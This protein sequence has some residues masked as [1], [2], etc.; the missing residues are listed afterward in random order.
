MKLLT[1]YLLLI[2][3]LSASTLNLSMSSSPSRLNPI[4]ANDS[5][6][7][8]ISDWL[9]NGLFKYDKN[10]NHTVD[11]AQSYEYETPTKL[12]IKLRNNVLWHDGVKFTSKDVVFTYEKIIDPKVFNSIKS[13]FQEVQSVKA[14]DDFTL[15]IIYKQP[16]FKAIETWM[17]GI[18]PYHLLKDE[19]NLMT[20]SFNK[21]PIGTGSYKLKEFK[22][23]QD[24]ELIANE[25][26]FEGIPKIDKILY[27]FLPDPNTSFL[28]LKQKK[29]DIGG[30]TPIQIDRQIDDDFKNKFTIIQKPSF[31]Y[32]YLGFNLNNEKFKDLRIRQALSLAIDRQELVDILFFG[33]GKICNGPFLPDSFAYNEKI[34]PITQNIEKAKELLKELGYDENNPFTFEVVTNTGNDTRINTA[35]ILQYQLEKVGVKMTIRVMEWQA[36]LNTV[37]HPKK[38]DAVILGWSLGLMP[39][40]YPLWHSSSD[41]LGGFN[42]VSY[43]N[44][45]VDK[46][47]EDGINTINREELGKIYK[48]IFKIIS[49]DLPYLFLYIPDGI[50]VVN[51]EIKNVEPSFIGIMHNQKDWELEQ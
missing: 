13:N 16:Y 5:A 32:T 26:Y 22:T 36:F 33:Y 1:Y 7:S 39:D 40:A 6:S 15:E 24:I 10:G 44:E 18:L 25:N 45:K 12:I 14:I 35:Q 20:S 50:T 38:F 11:L 41:K 43:K 27:Q 29:L 28:Y 19:E 30:L 46:L 4:L 23:A 48:E 34:K 2:T 3:Y 8:E 9:F 31:A 49:D 17:V 21:N 47:I 42:L 51:K 37:V